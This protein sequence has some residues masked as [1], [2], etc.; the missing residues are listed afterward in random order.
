VAVVGAAVTMSATTSMVVTGNSHITTPTLLQQITAVVDQ[1]P[2]L[3]GAQGYVDEVYS[4]RLVGD[5]N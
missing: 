2:A 1:D 5:I 4:T 3:I